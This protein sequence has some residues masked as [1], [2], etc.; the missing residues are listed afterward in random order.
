MNS[1]DWYIN[2]SIVFI[3]SQ[4]TLFAVSIH[5]SSWIAF[6]KFHNDK[7]GSS[8]LT[9]AFNAEP[10]YV[11]QNYTIYHPKFKPQPTNAK[12]DEGHFRILSRIRGNQAG[13]HRR[14]VEYSIEPEYIRQLLSLNFNQRN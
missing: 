9:Q 14:Q 11:N 12:F 6:E 5:A 3:E 1:V 4:A 2:S 10:C 8:L 7:T 13:I